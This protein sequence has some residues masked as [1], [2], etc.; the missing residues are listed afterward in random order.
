MARTT[1]SKS[2]SGLKHLAAQEHK[3]M[4]AAHQVDSKLYMAEALASGN[5]KRIERYF[6][7][8]LAYKLFGRFL[9]KTINRI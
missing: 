5:P 4:H 8:R 1:K 9:A 7:R 6:L 3:A 2:G